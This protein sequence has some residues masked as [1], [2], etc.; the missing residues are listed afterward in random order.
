MAFNFDLE[1]AIDKIAQIEDAITTP[2]PGIVTAYGFGDNPASIDSPA[3]LPAVVHIPMGPATV[4]GEADTPGRL[5]FARHR[6]SYDVVSLVLI[7]EVIPDVYPSD[8]QAASLFWKPICEAFFNKTN[9]DAL[10]AAAACTSYGC[11]LDSPCYGVR[12]WP[13]APAEPL[14]YYYSYRYTH[15]FIFM[16]A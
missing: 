13:P 6:L 10:I 12:A 2:S 15:R 16:E 9:I 11:I 1:D 14:H 5:T 3:L 4:G 7:S 8:E